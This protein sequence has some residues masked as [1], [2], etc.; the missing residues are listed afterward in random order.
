MD[1]QSPIQEDN[2]DGLEQ[3]TA[4][5]ESTCGGENNGSSQDKTEATVR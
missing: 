2:N 4:N 1:V 5:A 3:N